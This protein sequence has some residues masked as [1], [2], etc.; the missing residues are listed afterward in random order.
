MVTIFTPIYNRAYIIENLYQSLLRQTSFNFE[1]LILDDGS[2]D[3]ISMIVNQW[4]K[5]TQKFEIRFYSQKNGGKHRAINRGV[6]LARGSAF[7][8]VDSDDYLTD[9]A[10]EII[11]KYWEPIEDKQ[12]FAGV[13]GLK[14]HKNE[15]V[16]GGSLCFAKFVDATNLERDKYGLQGD[17]A[18]VYKTDILKMFPFPEYEGEN[19]ITE[20]V[21]WNEIA[22]Q[23]YKIR[24]FNRGIMVCDYLADGL[25][26]RG[27]QL[28]IDNPKGWSDYI[29]LY[30]KCG[31]IGEKDYLKY[32]FY[33]YESEHAKFSNDEFSRMLDLKK[34]EFN[35]ILDRYAEFKRELTNL[36]AD[37]RICIYA[38]GN[39]GKRLKHYLDEVGVQVNYVIDRKYA[40]IKD[41]KAY[42]LDAELP[43]TE[44]IFIALKDGVEGAAEALKKKMPETEIVSFGDI[45]PY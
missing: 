4:I 24:W 15:Q 32:C 8:I 3:N 45:V 44:L 30:K 39:W 13:S 25:T 5:N 19:F 28:F 31:L 33:F 36:C 27:I 7:F 38:Y 14:M 37:K 11:S 34:E 16:I 26:A 12:E 17:K 23:G 41:I 35:V 22:Y 2:T 40:D 20:A 9:D 6:Q 42:P 21:V 1:W 10:V 29:R 18:E 43:G